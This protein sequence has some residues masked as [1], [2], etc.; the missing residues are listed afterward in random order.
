M[1]YRLRRNIMCLLFVVRIAL[2]P[3]VV[4]TVIHVKHR[5]GTLHGFIVLRSQ[6]GQQLATGEMIQT[7]EGAGVK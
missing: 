2:L 7:V 4:A 1:I 3:R 5:E 6:E